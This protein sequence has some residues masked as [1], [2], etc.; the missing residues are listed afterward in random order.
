M[1]NNYSGHYYFYSG[2]EISVAEK[3]KWTPYNINSLHQNN[4]AT[5]CLSQLNLL[6]SQLTELLQFSYI[7]YVYYAL[8]MYI[9]EIDYVVNL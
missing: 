6:Y 8:N 7:F 9:F 4:V 5:A 1:C 3:M 2:I